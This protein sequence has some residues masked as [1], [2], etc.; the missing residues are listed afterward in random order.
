MVLVQTYLHSQSNIGSITQ[1]QRQY[2]RWQMHAANGGRKNKNKK[3][4]S[5]PTFAVILLCTPFL[6]D[7]QCLLKDFDD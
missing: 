3:K 2:I 4:K 7:L 1:G 5:R 6:K